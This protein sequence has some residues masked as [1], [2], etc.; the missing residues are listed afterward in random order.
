MIIHQDTPVN[1]IYLSSH[2]NDLR[3]FPREE[4]NFAPWEKRQRKTQLYHL[5][6]RFMRYLYSIL[7]E[8]CNFCILCYF[9]LRIRG[10]ED[11]RAFSPLF[12]LE[13]GI[14]RDGPLLYG[15]DDIEGS[16][17]ATVLSARHSKI[18]KPIPKPKEMKSQTLEW[19]AKVVKNAK[20]MDNIFIIISRSLANGS[21]IISGRT[22]NSDIE[23]L[24]C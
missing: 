15:R 16:E 13:D 17:R 23:Y 6:K 21:V 22:N 4:A 9:L 2:T 20:P 14:A 8:R 12:S 3:V 19:L 24:Y 5:V 7:R 11:S 1:I 18:Y 10:S